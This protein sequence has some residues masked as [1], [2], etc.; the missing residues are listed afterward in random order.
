MEKLVSQIG[1]SVISSAAVV[2]LFA[3]ML[4]T[5]F[6][7]WTEPIFAKRVEAIRRESEQSLELIRQKN[8]KEFEVIRS[9]I[10]FL[11]TA[12]T[13]LHEYQLPAFSS[14][15]TLAYRAKTLIT[16]CSDE[17]VR[18]GDSAKTLG[19][20][21]DSLSELLL[22]NRLLIKDSLFDSL[23]DFKHMIDEFRV[24]LLVVENRAELLA[25]K[26]DA[27]S[28]KANAMLSAY[29]TLIHQ[30]QTESGMRVEP[31]MNDALRATENRRFESLTTGLMPPHRE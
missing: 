11:K 16:T 14:F 9:D 29:E 17:E 8:A 13:R 20:I 2:S 27:I 25:E 6:D 28:M 7:K 12:R 4:R 26:R 31:T 10:E 19:D 18:T 22:L 30:L 15:A 21:F 5:V 24:L 23:H 3:Y 1:I